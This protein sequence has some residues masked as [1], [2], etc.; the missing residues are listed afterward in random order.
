MKKSM[1]ATGLYRLDG[2]TRADFELEAYAAALDPLCDDLKNL[3]KESFAVTAESYGLLY[4]ESALGVPQPAGTSEGRRKTV[5]ALGAAGAEGF[6]AAAL[7]KLLT[8]LGIEAKVTEDVPNRKLTLRVTGEPP[9]G[10]AAWE[11]LVG[12]FLPAHLTAAW[13][14]GGLK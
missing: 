10:T 3:Q 6:G 4:A 7:K 1:L 9:G 2:S 5:L 8:D 14:Y 12:R 11:K 13:D